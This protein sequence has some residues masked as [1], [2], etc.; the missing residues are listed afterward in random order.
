MK[1]INEIT[2]YEIDGTDQ[3][4][5]EDKEYILM[6]NCA[7]MFNQKMRAEERTQKLK[8][9]IQ[10]V[11]RHANQETIHTGYSEDRLKEIAELTKPYI[12]E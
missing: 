11:Y 10:K 8:Q 12:G 3:P 2:I 4:K 6:K 7:D 5:T 1:C 9:V